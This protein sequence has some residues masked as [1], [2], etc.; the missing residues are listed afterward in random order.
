MDPRA[1]RRRIVVVSQDVFLFAG[2][3]GDNIGL[4]DPA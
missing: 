2:T 4:G 3:L 1:L